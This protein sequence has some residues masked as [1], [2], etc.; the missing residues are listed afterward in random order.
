MFSPK[1]V[2]G[3]NIIIFGYSFGASFT[4]VNMKL[5]ELVIFVL[6]SFMN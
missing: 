4:R 5:G 6:V 1:Y 2:A 3:T